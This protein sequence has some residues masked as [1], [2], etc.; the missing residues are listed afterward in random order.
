MDWQSVH[1]LYPV[2]EESIWLNNCGTVP[3][4]R[5][6]VERVCDYLDGY[7]KKGI[8]T[9]RGRF[10]DVR[11]RIKSI[12]AGLLNCSPEELALIHHT[13]EGMNMV[14]HGIDFFRGDEV[15]LLENEYPSNVYPWKHLER[16]GVKLVVAPM[17]DDPD[18]FL[19]GLA[20]RVSEKTKAVSVSAVHWC[21]GIPL[22]LNRI[23]KFCE[24]RGIEFVVDGAQGVGMRPIDVREANISFMAFSAWKWLMGPL[25]LGVF[26]VAK[27]KLETLKPEIVGTGSVVRDEEYLPYKTELKPTADRFTISTPNFA[28]WIYFL[29]S[30]EFLDRIGFDACIGRIYELTDLLNDG[31]RQIG[32]RVYSDRAPG[33]R[34][35]IT[36]FETPNVPASKVLEVLKN[37][38]VVAAE[39]LG[40]VRL[41]PHI[42]LLP[43]QLEKA[44]RIVG[45]EFGLAYGGERK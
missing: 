5:H 37:N 8:F 6:V 3:A 19:K 14:S 16:K 20:E 23:G 32:C 12:L 40:R 24:D 13:A 15:V 2:N 38:N 17:E 10:L 30:L 22:P 41:A 26:Y 45:L 18:A 43:E 39:R 25:G 21:T 33:V 36:V 28:D 7:S 4:G 31:L 11:D 29:A 35:G 42:Y 27:E 44:V 34:T 1:E 9:D